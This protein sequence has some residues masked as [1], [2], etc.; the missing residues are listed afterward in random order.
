M[1]TKRRW[2]KT[3]TN[4]FFGSFIVIGIGGWRLIDEPVAV[5]FV[6]ELALAFISLSAYFVCHFIVKWWRWYKA[7][8][9]KDERIQRDWEKKNK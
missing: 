4:F 5:K 8:N 2:E 1:K 3:L 7:F 9:Y 6:L